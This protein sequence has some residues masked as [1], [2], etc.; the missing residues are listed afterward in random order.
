M[1]IAILAHCSS[2]MISYLKRI[3]RWFPQAQAQIKAQA[4]ELEA[5][6]KQKSLTP[7]TYDQINSLI[8]QI[9]QLP[10]P[11]PYQ[12]TIYSR[13]LES[14][15]HWRQ[16]DTRQNSLVIL[17][18]PVEP[19]EK[20]IG[21]TLAECVDSVGNST[22]AVGKMTRPHYSQVKSQLEQLVSSE[23][24]II[25]IPDLSWCFLRC[26][27]GL[28][29][30]E[31]LKQLLLSQKQSHFWLIGC[32]Y[33]AWQYLK[34]VSRLEVY[35]TDIAELPSLEGE[36][37]HNW[38]TPVV[39]T[40]DFAES[41]DVEEQFPKYFKRLAEVALGNS[42]VAAKIWLLSLGWEKAEEDNENSDNQI[43]MLEYPYLPDLPHLTKQDRYLL[44]SLCLH[45]G[46]DL[47]AL[48]LSLGDSVSLVQDQVQ[49]LWQ[50][51]FLWEYNHLLRIN[52][53]YYPKLL[54]DLDN[55]YL[56]MGE[57]K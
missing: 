11:Q 21:K 45:G 1:P 14:L 29:G 3:R 35:C 7:L 28:E 2:Q 39:E 17:G 26:V 5:K 32:N 27:D 46:L 44:F 13:L 49:R 24:G 12:A 48:A 18:S 51:D 56:L 8:S 15:N 30:I 34:V 43:T 36:V 22:G 4:E 37:L 50:L 38:L 55:N 31:F 6:I 9:E 23:P 53:A 20:I 16:G 25:F 40:I 57:G 47:E 42:A 33:W 41:E 19:L 54:R 52:P 10:T